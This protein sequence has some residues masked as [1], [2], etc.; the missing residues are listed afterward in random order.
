MRIF[1]HKEEKMNNRYKKVL[2]LLVILSI[3]TTI[4]CVSAIDN[5]TDN[6]TISNTFETHISPNGND[7]SGDGSQENPYNSL[8]YA[9]NYTSNEST[10]YLEEGNYA[11]ENNR[12]ITLDKSV[13]IIGKSKENTI[14]DCELSGRLFTMNSNSKLTLINLTLKNGNLTDNGGL[15]YNAGGQITIKNCILSDSQG[16]KNGGSIYNNLGALNIENTAFINNSAFEYGGVIY[17]N[18]QTNIKN[19]NFTQNFLTAK[20][21]GRRLHCI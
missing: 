2:L 16:Y 1:P 12:N 6:I 17:T 8:R 21:R 20:K 10:I 3:M 13:T 9:I 11:G 14:I 18:G 15:I 4:N 5:T 7:Y 19:S